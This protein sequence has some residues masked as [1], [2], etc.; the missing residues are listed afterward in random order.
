MLKNRDRYA[1]M[2]LGQDK[3]P[4]KHNLVDILQIQKK[5]K[6]GK[7]GQPKHKNQYQQTKFTL[8]QNIKLPFLSK[9]STHAVKNHEAAQSK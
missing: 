8:A 2:Q 4:I 1:T 7:D 3:M 9:L 5:K 6:N